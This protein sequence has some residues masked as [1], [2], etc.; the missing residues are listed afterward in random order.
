[1][2]LTVFS[3]LGIVFMAS[4]QQNVSKIDEVVMTRDTLITQFSDS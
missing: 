1:M 4:C 2:K 3:L